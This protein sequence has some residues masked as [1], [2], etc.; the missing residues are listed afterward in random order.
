MDKFGHHNQELCVE[1]W[2]RT[3]SHIYQVLVF[4]ALVE[5]LIPG[6]GG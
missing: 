1:K 3:S 4:V 2:Q 6:S 5:W